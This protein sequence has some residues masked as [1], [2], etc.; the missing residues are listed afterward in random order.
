MATGEPELHDDSPSAPGSGGSG[1]VVPDGTYDVFIVDARADG[2]VMHLDLV[3]VAG[4][5][6]GEVVPVA[7]TGIERDEIDLVGLPATV[8]VDRGTPSVSIES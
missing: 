8:A 2:D 1:S 7:A 4:E 6:K 5:H 3:I